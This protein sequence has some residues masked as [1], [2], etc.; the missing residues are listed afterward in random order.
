MRAT[1][2]RA[3]R[4]RKI[5]TYRRCKPFANNGFAGFFPR[6]ATA[7]RL[8][9][10]FIHHPMGT[11]TTTLTPPTTA[12]ATDLSPVHQPPPAP[13]EPALVSL[14]TLI[15][16]AAQQQQRLQAEQAAA[17]AADLALQARSAFD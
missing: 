7:G 8:N 14:H 11:M 3:E 15:R 1:D 13:A 4:A 2:R 10:V 17:R 9:G 6:L 16:T 12:A 5:L